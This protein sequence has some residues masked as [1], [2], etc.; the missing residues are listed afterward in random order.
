MV[1]NEKLLYF[2]SYVPVEHLKA[3]GF[4]MV[5]PGDTDALLAAGMPY[6]SSRAV[7]RYMQH[8]ARMDFS[9]YDGVIFTHC[10]SSAERVFDFIQFRYPGLFL[11]MLELPGRMDDT[12]RKQLAGEYRRLFRE[13]ERRF[14]KREK[15]SSC[16]RKTRGTGRAVWLL[17][18][19]L[20]PRWKNAV[21]TIFLDEPLDFSDCSSSRHG[22]RFLDSDDMDESCPHMLDFLPWFSKRLEEKRDDIRAVI[23]VFVPKCDFSLFTMPQ[24]RRICHEQ[25][26]PV[27]LLEEEFGPSLSEQNRIRLEAFREML[28]RKRW[29]TKKTNK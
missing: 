1:I 27:L 9:R 2:C 5:G 15:T 4:V 14:G 13:L 17:G 26:C 3:R 18:N 19:S 24:I 23:G 20:H 25:N 6:S 28:E 22:D 16:F 8:C 21:Q 10:C 7:C 29:T 11:H 12:G